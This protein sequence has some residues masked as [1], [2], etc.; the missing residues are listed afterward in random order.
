MTDEGFRTEEFNERYRVITAAV[1]RRVERRVIGADYGANS[2]TTMA[3]AD[4][5]ARLLALRRGRLL[6]DVGSGAGWPAV[7]LA[8]RTGCRAVLTDMPL[9]GLM[10]AKRRMADRG[11][12]GLVVAAAGSRLP[13]PEGT[14]DGATSSDVMC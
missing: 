13:F 8:E 1:M 7:Y 3:Q 9:E 2:Y 5:L 4:R 12:D 6:L 10:V 11:I 14:F